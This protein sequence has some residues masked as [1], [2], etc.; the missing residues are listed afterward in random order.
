MSTVDTDGG[1]LEE[2]LFPAVLVAVGDEDDE[3]HIVRGLD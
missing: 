1:R 2:D 3:E